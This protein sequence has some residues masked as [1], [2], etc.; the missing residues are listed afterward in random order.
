MVQETGEPELRSVR[1]PDR[2]VEMDDG[3][4]RQRRSTGVAS[5]ALFFRT[6][7]K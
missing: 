3:V 6:G 7:G 4:V 1:S 5:G 2:D